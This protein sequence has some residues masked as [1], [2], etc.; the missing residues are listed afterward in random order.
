MR[1]RAVLLAGA[2][3]ITAAALWPL[4]YPFEAIQPMTDAESQ[5]AGQIAETYGGDMRMLPV[6]IR[7]VPEGVASDRS[8][9]YFYFRGYTL[10]GIPW[11]KMRVEYT[12]GKAKSGAVTFAWM[13]FD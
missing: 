9:T 12:D 3:L 13:K 2:I 8:H 11:N 6:V 1:S 7:I 4:F 5:T 10:F